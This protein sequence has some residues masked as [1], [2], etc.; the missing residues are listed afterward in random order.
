MNNAPLRPTTPGETPANIE[1]FVVPKIRCAGLIFTVKVNTD[2][3]TKKVWD[4]KATMDITRDAQIRIRHEAERKEKNKDGSTTTIPA[5]PLFREWETKAKYGPVLFDHHV[6]FQETAPVV[7]RISNDDAMAQ[8]AAQYGISKE[9]VIA[10]LIQEAE[11][12]EKDNAPP[13]NGDASASQEV[14]NDALN[15]DEKAVLQEELTES[16]K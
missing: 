13:S 8:L 2:G 4:E 15:D 14:A 5:T 16:F 12:V 7:A 10:M 1:N 3:M 11:L 9:R 6:M